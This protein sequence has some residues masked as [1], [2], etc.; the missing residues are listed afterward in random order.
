MTILSFI[1]CENKPFPGNGGGAPGYTHN[2]LAQSF[3]TNLNLDA[4][5]D[6]SLIKSTT[7]KY[8]FVVIYDPYTDSYEAININDYDPAVSNASNYYYDSADKNYY[9]L[10]VIPGHYEIDFRQVN[11]GFDE[12]GYPITEYETY[13]NWVDTSYRDSY[14][15][16]VFEKIAATPKDLAK[17][18]ALKEVAVLD[19]KAKFLAANFGLS[20]DRGDE[21]ARLAA[22]WKK[23]SIKGMTHAEQDSFSTELLGFSITAGKAVAKQATEGNFSGVQDLVDQAAKVNGI[24]PEHATKLMTKV[25]GL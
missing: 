10:A 8:N 13:N 2:E 4:E 12:Y 23:S 6:V 5:F 25:F 9:N 3:V 15:G 14:T 1:G 22:H 24:T 11:V 21:V 18:A 19:K 16:F 7:F 17:V 20:L